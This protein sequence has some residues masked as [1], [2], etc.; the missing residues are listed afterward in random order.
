MD[1]S[2]GQGRI[3]VQAL[4]DDPFLSV[5]NKVLKRDTIIINIVNTAD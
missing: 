4:G 5:I 1:D 3:H 2:R